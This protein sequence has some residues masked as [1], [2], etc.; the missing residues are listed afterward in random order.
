MHGILNLLARPLPPRD[1]L[2]K[3]NV[4]YKPQRPLGET[5]AEG[6]FEPFGYV[7]EETYPWRAPQG[8]VRWVP[9]SEV[10]LQNQV[11]YDMDEQDW[12]WLQLINAERRKDGGT[13]SN[14]PEEVFEVIMDRLEKEWFDLSSRIPKP[15]NAFS[16]D[17]SLCAICD[18]DESEGINA[19]VFCDGCNLA[20]HQGELSCASR[21]GLPV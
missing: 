10:E 21:R 1:S 16:Q 12:E 15:A 18:N 6:S 11:E 2:P 17:D 14:V 7:G 13:A 19:I 9:P 3:I 4:R 20:V 8:Y 5:L